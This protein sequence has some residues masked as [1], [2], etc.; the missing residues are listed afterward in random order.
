MSDD[1]KLPGDLAWDSFELEH[2]HHAD[3]RF[4]F[5]AGWEAR[6]QFD[7]EPR[8][9]FGIFREA[10]V[11]MKGQEYAQIVNVTYPTR[12]DAERAAERLPG[13]KRYG[14]EIVIRERVA[15]EWRNVDE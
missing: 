5:A 11:T 13:Y 4:A 14:V 1:H 3:A 9:Q 8:Q 10:G 15:S 7:R 6:R 12:E 2:G